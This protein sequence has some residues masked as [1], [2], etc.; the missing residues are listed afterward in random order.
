MRCVV[1]VMPC[2]CIPFFG[3]FLG[4]CGFLFVARARFRVYKQI[5]KVFYV[6]S[7]DAILLVFRIFVHFGIQYIETVKFPFLSD[8][9]VND[10][11]RV[12]GIE[13]LDVVLKKGKG[14]ILLSAHLGNWEALFLYFSR[15]GY[16][17]GAIYSTL[18][19]DKVDELVRKWR[20]L[21]GLQLFERR[22]YTR[23][24]IRFLKK[25]GL[26]F[27]L[28]DQKPAGIKGI[29][30][31]FLGHKTK[32]LNTP[33]ILAARNKIPIVPVYLVREN[34]RQHI[35]IKEPLEI[36]DKDDSSQAIEDAVVQLNTMV[37]SWVKKYPE[38][39]SWFY[40]KWKN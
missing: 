16:S 12:S 10:R 38:Q 24:I 37:E 36:N 4:G 29:D 6:H 30:G 13:N 40:E 7:F 31:V 9:C 26:V 27:L 32:I 33:V 8:E 11:Y 3:T 20:S 35:Y 2:S 22:S 1:F 15:K 23:R 34:G 18:I 5:K 28:N 39:W 25:N 21:F 17:V 19:H 14:G